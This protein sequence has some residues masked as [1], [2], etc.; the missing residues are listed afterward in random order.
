MRHRIFSLAL[1][2][3]LVPAASLEAQVDLVALDRVH[4]LYTNGQVRPA[5]AA[6][7]AVSAEFRQEIGRC[8]D[9]EIGAKLVELEPRIDALVQRLR[10]DA[11][12]NVAALT[13]EFVVFDRLLAENHAQLAELGWSLRR[14][15]NLD[16]VGRDLDL[17]ARYVAR[18]ARWSGQPLDDA[19]REIVTAARKAA[20]ALI[21]SP[22]QPP[23]DAE[24]AIAGLATL[25]RGLH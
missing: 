5:A 12:P 19:S 16:A 24:R 13:S 17:A 18:S 22:D 10:N 11:V 21:E 14:F 1:A 9:P 2:A 7:A 6:L 23:A 4:T 20:A 25:V 15:G 8:K 3:L